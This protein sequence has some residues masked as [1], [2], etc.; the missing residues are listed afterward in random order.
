LPFKQKKELINWT[1]DKLEQDF[2]AM[3]YFKLMLIK[4]N[5]MDCITLVYICLRNQ[6]IE[7]KQ[8]P[9]IQGTFPLQHLNY[10]LWMKN[11]C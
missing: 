6:V 1:K 4:L 2:I 11:R 5:V 3:A 7:V 9:I 8:E 10:S